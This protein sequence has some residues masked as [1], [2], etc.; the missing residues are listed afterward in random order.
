MRKNSR[1]ERILQGA[2]LSL[3]KVSCP[4][5][6][7]LF[8]ENQIRKK[9]ERGIL[10]K[11][12]WREKMMEEK[13]MTA[14]VCAFSRAYH[15]KNNEVKIF[16]DDV[17]ENL[18]TKEEYETISENM[19]NGITY[20]NPDFKGSKQEGVRWVVDHM[21]SAVPLGRA[22]FAEKSLEIAVLHGATQYLIC[23]AGYDTFAYR[24]P[25]WA[26]QL[27]IFELDYPS[28][29]Q[30]KQRRVRTAEI[31]MPKNV[32][33]VETDFSM[34]GWENALREKNAFHENQISFCSLLGIIYYLS[35]SSFEKMIETIA[36][37]IP[38]NSSLVFDYPNEHYFDKQKKHSELA[39][40]S[41]EEMQS[42][43]SYE[44]MEKILEKH[45][46]L[47]FEHLNAD[48]MT[49][50]YFEA[51]NTANPKHHMKAQENVNY[52]LA[53]KKKR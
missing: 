43:Y 18:L 41:K 35:A 31:E 49:Q 14:R 53:V 45:H 50:Q 29:S 47:I 46:F 28:T 8:I 26:Q 7:A 23:A 51:Y 3:Y 12:V 4:N 36:S 5:L 33:Y 52:C 22:A 13:G 2:I 20:F 15:R 1:V 6:S 42:C 48:E 27:Q 44:E 32:T 37:I 40:A 30:D 25:E 21:L 19:G 11:E 39:K 17:V 9:V 38:E 10:I 34:E 16:D 24:Q